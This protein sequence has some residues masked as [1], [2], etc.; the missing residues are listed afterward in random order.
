[1][2]WSA[3]L[4]ATGFLRTASDP[5]YPGYTEP[6]EIHQVL[7]DT[8]QIVGSTFLGITLQC[9]RCHAHKFD[10]ISQRD[11]YAFQSIFL[12]ALDPAR[13]QPSEVRGIPLATD[14]ELAR[15]KA[16]NQKVA[17]RTKAIEAKL[18][19]LTEAHRRRRIDELVAGQPEG[20]K[21]AIRAALAHACREA[22]S[23]RS[24]LS[25]NGSDPRPALRST[26]LP[27]RP[28]IADYKKESEALKAAIASESARREARPR[29]HPWAD[30][31]AR[32]AAAGANPEAR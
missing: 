5:T 19:A 17:E 9:A 31:S 32:K 30:R 11:Y 20:L 8:M 18:A 21:P 28:M 26:N 24:K 7:N 6:N 14:S 10:P 25:C 29:A 2:R 13:W 3:Q 22:K 16:E 12:P 27:W 23:R 15:L 1:M 4:T